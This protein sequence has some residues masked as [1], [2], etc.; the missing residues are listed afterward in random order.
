MNRKIKATNGDKAD[1]SLSSVSRGMG[2]GSKADHER[3]VHLDWPSSLTML[4]SHP[5]TRGVENSTH[6]GPYA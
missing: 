4:S 5:I 6:F 3:R 1:S 2:S